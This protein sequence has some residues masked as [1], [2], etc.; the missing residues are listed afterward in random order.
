MNLAKLPL[1]DLVA[2]LFPHGAKM[3]VYSRL[4]RQPWN[5]EDVPK[6]TVHESRVADRIAE[7]RIHAGVIN[8]MKIYV[9]DRKRRDGDS[10]KSVIATLST[11]VR[12]EGDIRR[13]SFTGTL[14]HSLFKFDPPGWLT[15]EKMYDHFDVTDSWLDNMEI[16]LNSN[17]G[18]DMGVGRNG[19]IVYDWFD[20]KMH[21][22][23][24]APRRPVSR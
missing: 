19:K 4:T 5:Y 21:E 8:D 20:M 10:A 3:E 14:N 9:L 23:T 6:V 15:F 13:L 11:S 18:A 2:G 1:E 17:R 7:F 24:H 22:P 12:N 16:H